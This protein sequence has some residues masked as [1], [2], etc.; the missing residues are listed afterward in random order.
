VANEPGAT[1]STTAPAP[2]AAG[3]PL[4]LFIICARA[5]QADAITMAAPT[6][7][8]QSKYL[9]SPLPSIPPTANEHTLQV[10]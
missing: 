10:L 4:S 6:S 3:A 1:Y 9:M 2:W 5:G 7:D 8:V